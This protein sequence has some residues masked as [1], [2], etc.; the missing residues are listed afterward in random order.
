MTAIDIW[1]PAINRASTIG[2]WYT[3]I[4]VNN[5]A[6]ETG[7]ITDI[8]IRANEDMWWIKVATFYIVSWTTFTARDMVYIGDATS[9]SKQTFSWL[10]LNVNSWDYIW[11][12]FS[13]WKLERDTYWWAV[14]YR[15]LIWD[16]T[17]SAYNDFVTLQ[18][19]DI[20]SLYWI[21]TTVI[22]TA[23]SNASFLYLMV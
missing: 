14:W 2:D 20:I 7:I 10:S 12:Y 4:D 11:I 21:W 23:T 19:L 15:P 13:S 22:P 18:Q 17:E 6:N 5:P 1:M 8:E 3:L 9:G 16:W